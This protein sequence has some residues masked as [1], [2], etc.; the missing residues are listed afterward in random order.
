MSDPSLTSGLSFELLHTEPL[1]FVARPGHPL[2][3]RGASARAALAYPLVIYAEGTIPRHHTE[4]FLAS[5]GLALPADALQT[6]DVAVASALSA[7]SDSIWI[8]P[9]GAARNDLALGR[10]VRLRIATPGTDEPV[11]LLLRTDAAPSPARG[12][13]VALLRDEAR[14]LAAGAGKRR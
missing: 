13:L 1:V 7:G 9:L 14:R 12:A 10:L 11:G 8:T 2:A 4:S 6:L 5:L 3:R